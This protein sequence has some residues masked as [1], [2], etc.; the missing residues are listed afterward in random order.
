MNTESVSVFRHLL[1]TTAIRNGIENELE[2]VRDSTPTLV[3]RLYQPLLK[4]ATAQDVR[5]QLTR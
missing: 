5:S 2:L 4:L 3:S 1:P